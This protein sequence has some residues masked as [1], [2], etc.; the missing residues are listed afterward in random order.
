MIERLFNHGSMPVT[1][2]LVQFTAA[3]HRVILD[4]IANISTPNFRPRDL[5]VDSFQQALGKAI[6]AR[7]EK[8]AGSNQ[9]LEMADTR[10]LR[11]KPNGIEIKPQHAGDGI[12]FHDRNDRSVEHEMKNL[13]ENT[14][15]HNMALDLLRSQYQ[16]MEAA[17]RERI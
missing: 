3:R 16:L 15:T 14:M 13:A 2:R 4:N 9:P 11:F 12:L 10:E 6:D 17:I 1:E 5:S 8:V 7:R